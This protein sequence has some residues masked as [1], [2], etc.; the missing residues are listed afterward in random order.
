MLPRGQVRSV[1]MHSHAWRGVVDPRLAWCRRTTGLVDV[2]GAQLI[3]CVF[4]F[5]VSLDHCF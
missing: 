2:G 1:G 5:V 4:W 3:A